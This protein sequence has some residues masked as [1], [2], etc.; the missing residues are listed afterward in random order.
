M[1]FCIHHVEW[2]G[3]KVLISWIQI[4]LINVL[5][6]PIKGEEIYENIFITFKSKVHNKPG[7]NIWVRG[8]KHTVNIAAALTFC[9]LVP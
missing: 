4:G 2:E 7:V 3:T 8:R 1:N 9:L 6:L 5:L